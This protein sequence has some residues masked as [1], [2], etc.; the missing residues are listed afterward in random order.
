[1]AQNGNSHQL[2]T[3][4][5]SEQL[6]KD[7]YIDLREK[8]RIWSEITK[9]T[10]QARMGYIGQHLVSIA[11]GYEGS[12]SGARG[13]DL[14]IPPK[15]FAEI[16]TC[17]KVDQLGQ[18]KDCKCTVSVNESECSQC[19]STNIIRKDDSK[20]LISI[21]N[22]DEFEKILSPMFYFLVL[23]EYSDL[24]QQEG[25]I[26][27][28]IWRVDP[29]NLGFALCMIDYYINIRSQ[30]S[31]KAPFNMW[32]YM[33]KFDIMKAELI[34]QATICSDNAIDTTF[35][36]G[37]QEPVPHLV[38][39]LQT[40]SRSSNLDVQVVNDF[41]SKIGC[42]LTNKTKKTAMLAELEKFRVSQKVPNSA[43]ADMLA[44]SLYHQR[45]MDSENYH[46][47]PKEFKR[48]F[49]FLNR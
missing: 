48:M 10:A 5:A 25:D 22:D 37:E 4:S 13:R 32:P 38:E 2:G 31:S 39:E 36:P 33:L 34:Y 7:I 35:F 6:I 9:Q 3:K 40:Y 46:L 17:S 28:S 44:I 49:E 42:K 11:T 15:D 47:I 43:I 1:M 21:R 20:W 29:R 23:F 45:I 19:G 41:S 18:C 12:K 8:L 30:S 14:N 27:A 16:K 24:T 26:L